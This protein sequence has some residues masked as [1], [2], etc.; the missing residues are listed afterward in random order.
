[1][2]YCS[3]A[4]TG[5]RLFDII[6]SLLFLILTS[7]LFLLIAIMIKLTSKGPILYK[8]MRVGLRGK[9]FICYKFRTM[10]EKADDQLK[11][12]LDEDLKLKEEWNLYHKLK[13]DPRLTLIGKF[14][15][16]TSLDELP[17]FWNILKGELSVVGPRPHIESQTQQIDNRDLRNKYLKI[18]SIKPGLTGIWQTQGRNALT[19]AER[20][21]LEEKYVETQSF[22]L[23]LSLIFKT[24]LILLTAKGAY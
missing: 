22:S 4:R 23:D 6:F 18:L 5:K 20:L 16:K 24:V 11:N 9:P 14:L 2:T 21:C 17:Q 10:C 8:G 15:R 13:H 3:Y 1:M 19:F 7:P 12:L